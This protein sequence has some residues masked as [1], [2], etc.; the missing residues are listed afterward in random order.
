MSCRRISSGNHPRILVQAGLMLIQVPSAAATPS[1]SRL[2][3]QI[4]S[5][6]WVRSATRCSR[7][8]FNSR[9]R[10]FRGVPLVHVAQ[11]GGDENAAVA[12]PARRRNVE[13]GAR[14]VLASRHQFNRAQ[15]TRR[16]SVLC[17]RVPAIA[18]L[19]EQ[20]IQTDARPAR[21]AQNR[22]RGPPRD[23]RTERCRW[24][25]TSG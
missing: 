19:F 17:A 7:L 21:T 2:T 4:R 18:G 22:S 13:E 25:P 12:H 5:R 8:E 16:R 24:R 3:C 9:K 15:S 23:W 11:D 14:S 1:M 10:L 6:S 20:V